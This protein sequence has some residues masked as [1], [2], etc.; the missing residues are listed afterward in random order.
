MVQLSLNSTRLLAFAALVSVI[1]LTATHVAGQVIEDKPDG[2]EG[3]GVDEKLGEQI[4]LNLKFRDSDGKVVRLSEL[5]T[6]D[7]PVLLSLNYS[8]CP[9][10]CRVQLNGLIDGLKHMEWSAGNQYTVIS[11][12][13]D[14]LETPIQAKLTKQRYLEDYGRAGVG[15]GFRFLTGPEE[16]IRKLAD[17][18]GFRYKYVEDRKEYAHTAAVMV[19]SPKGIVSRYLYGV[20][21]EPQTVRLSLVEAAE[22]KVGST[23]D[24][25]LLF[26]FHYDET[27]GRYGPVAKRIMTA[28]GFV[29]VVAMAIG[30]LPFWLRRQTLAEAHALDANPAELPTDANLVGEPS[31]SPSQPQAQSGANHVAARDN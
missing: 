1:S 31:V 9:M 29:T 26:C 21:F 30:L 20:L 14:P 28:G 13:I 12:S 19:C 5:I 6:D 10:L 22:G 15:S 23:V 8:S 7:R 11:V 4:P 18:V 17:A 16:N 25:I 27:T 2:I 24:R 3:V